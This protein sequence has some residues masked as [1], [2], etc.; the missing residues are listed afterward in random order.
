MKLPTPINSAENAPGVSM[1]E[2]SLI[3]ANPG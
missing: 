2:L 3:A 1:C